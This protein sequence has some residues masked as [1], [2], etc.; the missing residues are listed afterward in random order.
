MTDN[1]SYAIDQLAFD[2]Y[3]IIQP[4]I[5]ANFLFESGDF[6]L[7]D[8]GIAMDLTDSTRAF[9]SHGALSFRETIQ[10]LNSLNVESSDTT[11]RLGSIAEIRQH[12]KKLRDIIAEQM[13]TALVWVSDTLELATGHLDI[14]K[15]YSCDMS[16]SNPQNGSIAL[17]E[18]KCAALFFSGD[19]LK[20]DESD[21]RENV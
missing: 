20:D 7:S 5:F 9:I 10:L 13:P 1:P 17:K 18:H 8:F 11:W 2:Q 15:Y 21:E 16:L 6:M 19:L 4:Q 14:P 3:K 12:Q